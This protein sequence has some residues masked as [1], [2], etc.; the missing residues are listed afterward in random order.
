MSD[1]DTKEQIPNTDERPFWRAWLCRHLATCYH[2]GSVAQPGDIHY[3]FGS[4][5]ALLLAALDRYAAQFNQR[6]LQS[7]HE[8]EDAVGEGLPLVDWILE[9]FVASFFYPGQ[10]LHRASQTS[11]FSGC[12]GP[13]SGI[14]AS[15]S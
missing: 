4:K 11:Q 7:L 9:I 14:S 10:E 15:T 2:Q 12:P 3:R 8:V 5:E 13:S 1:V 6:R